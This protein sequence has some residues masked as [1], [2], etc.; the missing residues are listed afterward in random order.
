MAKETSKAQT[1]D[2]IKEFK[3]KYDP[4]TTI[5]N[6]ENKEFPDKS[7]NERK[8][9]VKKF[10]DD[11]ATFGVVFRAFRDSDMS[12]KITHTRLPRSEPKPENEA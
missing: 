10:Y 8:D 9:Y 2:E 7:T 12:K 4:R 3:L 5:A 1:I 11:N 6:E